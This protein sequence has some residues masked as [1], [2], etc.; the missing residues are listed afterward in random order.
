MSGKSK[1]GAM[2]QRAI[3]SMVG[4]MRLISRPTA[5]IVKPRMEFDKQCILVIIEK[6]TSGAARNCWH[7]A[8]TFVPESAQS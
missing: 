5:K 8:P 3:L 1:T 7:Q 6:P 2:G 4:P